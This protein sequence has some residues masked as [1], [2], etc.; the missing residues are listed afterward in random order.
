VVVT[1]DADVVLERPGGRAA[2]SMKLLCLL[3][4][5]PGLD[6][7]T[8][9]DHWLHHH[10]GLF[11]DTPELREPMYAYDQSHGLDLPGARWD[12]VTEQWFGSIEEWAS[13]LGI[14][15]RA[16]LVVPDMAAFLDVADLVP[17]VAGRPT[18]VIG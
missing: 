5:K 15:A 12:G 18:V 14:P 11:R 10:G 1:G 17:V 6:L 8:F 9:H 7:P 2:A 16:E 3:R 4:R 13:G